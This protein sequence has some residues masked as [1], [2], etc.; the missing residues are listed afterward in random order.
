[1]ADENLIQQT[2]DARTAHLARLGAVDADVMAPLVNP[3]LQGG[4]RWPD[5]RQSWR[6]VRRAASTIVVSDGLSDPFS[7]EDPPTVG[8]GLEVLAETS[9]ALA[10]A[11]QQTWVFGLAYHVAQQC[12][13][14]G[15]VR[16][17]IDE[18]G[19]VSLE[20]PRSKWPMPFAT[21]AGVTGVLLGV[22]VPP[23]VET[24]WALPAG[25]IRIVTAK[26]LWP[27]EL[28]YVVEQGA[29]GRAELVRRFTADGTFHVSSAQ[30]KPVV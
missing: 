21:P 11:V 23:G 5:M 1:M 30:R 15:G 26:A 29:V 6:I 16:G 19:T 20:L 13:A 17:L 3:S 14:H 28:D 7:D 27:S 10:E 18:L 24:E 12:A 2:F 4:P 22:P 8:Y 9:D 25:T